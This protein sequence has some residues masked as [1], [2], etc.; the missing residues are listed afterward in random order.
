MISHEEGVCGILPQCM[1]DV[2]KQLFELLLLD[3]SMKN[4]LLKCHRVCVLTHPLFLPLLHGREIL[5]YSF[6]VND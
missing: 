1:E 6:G 4:V 3:F 2:R 5:F